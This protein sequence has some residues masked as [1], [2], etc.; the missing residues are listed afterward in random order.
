MNSI[1][2]PLDMTLPLMGRHTVTLNQSIDQ[3]I[4][5]WINQ[6][7]EDYCFFVFFASLLEAA[8]IFLNETHW[9]CWKR[10]PRNN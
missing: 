10:R 9:F 1:F 8:V 5:Q 6:S 4:N 3:S 2:K 7:N